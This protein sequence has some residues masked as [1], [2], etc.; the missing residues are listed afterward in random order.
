MGE[1]RKYGKHKYWT[2]K[3]T[4]MLL[5]MSQHKT[6]SQIAKVLGRTKGSVDCKRQRMG[7]SDFSKSTDGIIAKQISYLVGQHSKSIYNKWVKA[8]LPLK[9]IGTKY[10]IIQEK[11]LVEFM[12]ENKHLWR[13]SECDYD[14]FKKYDWFLERL[15]L[16]REGKD[17]ISHYR[18]RKKWNHYELSRVKMF[19]KKGLHYTEIAEKV[20]RS[21]MAVYHKVRMFEDEE[22]GRR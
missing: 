5:S 17:D 6:S 8:G 21:R 10:R 3:E 19:W 9:N 2:E 4:E 20:G 18:D 13:A 14:F 1:I 11:E 7:I 15:K 22:W 12:K 16:E